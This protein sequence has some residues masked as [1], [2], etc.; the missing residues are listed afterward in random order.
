[1]KSSVS[2]AAR[3]TPARCTPGRR[4]PS[5]SALQ[6]A[7][8]SA[9]IALPML[10]AAAPA[11]AVQ[12]IVTDLGTLGGTISAASGINAFGHVVGYASNAGNV[13][14]HA[15]LWQFGSMQDLG[16]LGGT[17][18]FATGINAA[19]QVVGDSYTSGNAARRAFLW[20]AG[21]MRDLGTLGGTL[22]FATGINATGQ[23]EGYSNPSGDTAQHAFLWQAGSMQDL[24]TLGG[25]HSYATGINAAGLVVGNALTSGNAATHASL[26]HPG[27]ILDLGT[28]GGTT[29]RATGINGAGQV[30]GYSEIGGSG[31]EHA[32]LLQSNGGMQDLGTLG[33]TTSNANGINAAGQVVGFADT[34]GNAARHAFLRGPQGGMVN[35]NALLVAGSTATVT[36]AA[37]INDFGQIAGTATIAGAPRAVLLT[38]TGTLAWQGS[39][40]GGSFSDGANWE[41][42]FAPN[43]VFDAIIAPAGA[44]TLYA[45]VDATVR[46]LSLGGAAGSS[47]RPRLVL[48]NGANLSA[49]SGMTIQPTGTLTGDGTI[50]GH[51]TNLGT[52]QADNLSVSG[53]FINAGLISG[54]GYLNA[55]LSNAATGQVRSGAG[56]HLRLAGAVH[57]NLGTLDIS[58]GGTQQYT[59]NLL[60]GAGGRILLNNAVLRL[61]NGLSNS[62][63]VQVSFGGATVYGA[64]TTRA[65]GK[66]ILSGN[67]NSTFYDALDVESGGELRVSSGST[68]VFFGQVNQRTGSIFSGTGSKFY[69]GG[70]SIGG[71]PGLG[72]DAGN[73]SFGSG[74][75]YLEEIG[76]LAAGTEFDKYAVAG[77]LSFGGTLNVV[78]WGGFVGAEGQSFDLFDWGSSTG[79][80]SNLDFSAAPLAAGLTWDTS[81]L[82][83]TGEI[84][85][86]AVPEPGSWALLLA[87]LGIVGR[88]ARRA[89]QE[90]L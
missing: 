72:H 55:N 64:V 31:A 78:W 38:P 6:T 32:F 87:G 29:S 90:R 71:S 75:V 40:A 9:F 33:G 86:T 12:F 88:A 41:L 3:C 82:Y 25:T 27:G 37:A 61:D 45:S 68:A 52:L 44:Q 18:S 58:G 77:T 54:S 70:L 47:G 42:G 36:N 17:N 85:I 19:G 14:F 8:A 26:W 5:V 79:T 81:R 84:A 24:G 83:L 35:L 51:L 53:T 43:H 46:S 2:L 39:G 65:G 49:T 76:G 28:L 60:N 74:N 73:V 80:F 48:L 22:S 89:R 34:S 23:V 66:V 67:S 11:G 20:Q 50:S 57:G 30:V 4:A 59:G 10:F 16:T 63:Q 1:M 21:G 56:E 7:V 69:E 13:V 62:G 15:F